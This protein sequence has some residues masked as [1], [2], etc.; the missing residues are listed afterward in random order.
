MKKGNITKPGS[1]MP[2][3]IITDNVP[4]EESHAVIYIPEGEE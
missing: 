1:G 4:E 3:I 2:P